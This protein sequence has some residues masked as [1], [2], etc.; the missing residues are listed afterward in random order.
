MRRLLGVVLLA[1][2]ALA[3]FRALTSR[4]GTVASE[5]NGHS[6]DQDRIELLRERI[7]AARKRL[8]DEIDS[9]RGQ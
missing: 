1:A 6:A 7:E 2:A 9:V 3:A 8:Q 4:G 5:G